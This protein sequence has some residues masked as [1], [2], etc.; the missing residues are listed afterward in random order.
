M[1]YRTFFIFLA[2]LHCWIAPPPFH[3]QTMMMTTTMMVT[4]TPKISI[5]LSPS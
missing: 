1:S 3:H 5:D 2:A 4:K